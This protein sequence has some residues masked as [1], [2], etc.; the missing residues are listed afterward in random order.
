MNFK[1]MIFKNKTKKKKKSQKKNNKKKLMVIFW[2]AIYL[3]KQVVQSLGTAQPIFFA[4]GVTRG[5][6]HKGD[7]ALQLKEVKV[8]GDFMTK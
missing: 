5:Q 6:L 1:S 7:E 8:H 2:A 4:D 3:P